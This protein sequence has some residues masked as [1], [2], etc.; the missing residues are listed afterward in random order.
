MNASLAGFLYAGQ[1][2]ERLSAVLL[3]APG[4][5]RGQRLGADGGQVAGIFLPR[6]GTYLEQNAM[7]F[8]ETHPPDK[9]FSST[10]DVDKEVAGWLRQ[11]FHEKS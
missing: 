10:K 8:H 4:G 3:V 2:S 5:A 9:L 11:A 1:S 6:D 7:T